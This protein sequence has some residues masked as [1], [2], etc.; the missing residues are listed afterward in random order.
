MPFKLMLDTS[1]PSLPLIVLFS[2]RSRDCLPRIYLALEVEAN[3]TSSSDAGISLSTYR[4]TDLGFRS[5]P[6]DSGYLRSY[7][8]PRAS[9]G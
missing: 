5:P 7:L 4:P 8:C 3:M 2:H 9:C 1:C 6:R